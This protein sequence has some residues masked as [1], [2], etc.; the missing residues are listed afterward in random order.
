MTHLV[1]TDTSCL[2]ALDRVGLLDI[3]PRLFVTHAPRAVVDE[4][5]TCPSWLRVETARDTRHV[6][7]L[8][9]RLDRGEAEAIVLALSY[10]DARLL[11]DEKRGRQ[12]ARRLG[13]RV[14]GTAGILLAAKTA[15]LVPAVKPVLDALREK[16]NFRLNDA[17]YAQTV[18]EAGEA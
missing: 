5:G 9:R 14:T 1:V 11:I 12:V 3:L 17:L 10:P 8:E 18:A 4:F 13:L 2:I 7:Q 6:A 16:H 15:G